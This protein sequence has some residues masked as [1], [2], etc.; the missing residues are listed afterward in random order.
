MDLFIQAS[1][2]LLSFHAIKEVTFQPKF[3]RLP[4]SQTDCLTLNDAQS[5]H[6]TLNLEGQD[7]SS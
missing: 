2:M 5:A 6:W 7:F 4:N 1:G 3:Y